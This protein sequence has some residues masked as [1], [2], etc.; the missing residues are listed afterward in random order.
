MRNVFQKHVNHLTSSVQC[1]TSMCM[2]VCFVCVCVC[3]YVSVCMFVYVC[4]CIKLC[5]C[6]C[7]LLSSFWALWWHCKV[8]VAFG[9]FVETIGCCVHVSF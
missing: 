4:V 2:S 9:M 5:V 8:L 6:V 3:V 7:C 1:M